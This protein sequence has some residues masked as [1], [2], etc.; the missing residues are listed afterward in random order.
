M[1]AK[2]F[3]AN[4]PV[5]A[6]KATPHRVAMHLIMLD[7]SAEAMRR[8]GFKYVDAGY[9]S[10]VYEHR[11][12]PGVVFKVSNPHYFTYSPNCIGE[13]H[14]AELDG[15]AR[16]IAWCGEYSAEYGALPIMPKVLACVSRADKQVYVLERLT[17]DGC[18][19]AELPKEAESIRRLLI[20]REYLPMECKNTEH[21]LLW[22]RDKIDEVQVNVDLHPGNIMWRKSEG[23][24]YVL[25]VTD[26]IGGGIRHGT[27]PIMRRMRKA[28]NA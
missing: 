25:V 22:L 2:D 4:L 28:A 17:P 21:F 10:S 23:K 12:C 19:P 3:L 14:R 5:I 8:R 11:T 7:S 16:Y 9:Y 6:P 18:L 15:Y 13:Y 24:S 26:P 27:M 20:G 1:S